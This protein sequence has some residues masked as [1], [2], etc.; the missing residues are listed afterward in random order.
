VLI[1]QLAQLCEFTVSSWTIHSDDYGKAFGDKANIDAPIVTGPGY[2]S[3]FKKICSVFPGD[4]SYQFNYINAYDHMT[5]IGGWAHERINPGGLNITDA[6]W[7]KPGVI[8]MYGIYL[9][10]IV[11]HKMEKYAIANFEQYCVDKIR[12]AIE[13][14]VDKV[15]LHG[16]GI[17]RPKGIFNYDRNTGTS[18]IPGQI[19]VRTSG[20]SGVVTID[21]L[22]SVFYAVHPSYLPGASWLMHRKTMEAI[23]KGLNVTNSDPTETLF[24][25][26][27]HF[28]D[29]MPTPGPSSRAVIFGNFKKACYLIESTLELQDDHYN[30]K[31][32][33]AKYFTQYWGFGVV[34]TSGIK[35]L[36]LS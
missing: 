22:L 5:N 28:S 12:A 6:P 15:C 13:N 33:I 34:D 29:L 17:D 19:G 18:E 30:Y 16:S 20:T 11:T 24:G 14:E 36:E 27:V 1:W 9:Q 26:P 4:A 32:L 8:D 25:Y 3:V 7:V 35:I 31:P 10:P 23:R 2:D 21:G